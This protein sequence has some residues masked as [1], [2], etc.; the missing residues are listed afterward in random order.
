MSHC[1]LKFAVFRGSE[2]IADQNVSHEVVKLGSDP[3]SHIRLDDAR[4][5]RMHAVIESRGTEITLID[6]GN[7]GGT[8]VNG[9]R[10]DK[11]R[12]AVGDR[13]RMGD[14]EIVLE[15]TSLV[16]A[17]AKPSF[18][19]SDN[20]FTASAFAVDADALNPFR[21]A[22]R[23]A[24]ERSKLEVPA[25]AAPGTYTY[26]IVKSGPDVPSEEV[27]IAGSSAIEVTVMWG[28]SVLHVGHLPRERGFS[29]GE[30]ENKAKK[31]DFFLPEEKLGTSEL[32][33]V[34]AGGLLVIPPAATGFVELPGRARMTLDEAR[35]MGQATAEVA[36]G[37]SLALPQG[38]RARIELG[39]FA[40]LVAAVTA[41]KPARRGLFS[42]FDAAMGGFFGTTLFSAAAVVAAMAYFVPPLGLT[43]DESADRENAMLIQQ[44]L[45]TAAEREMLQREEPSAEEAQAA[46]ESGTGERHAGEEGEAGKPTSTATN[47]RYGVKNN[48]A[49]PQLAKEMTRTEVE[50]FGMIGLLNTGINADPNAPTSPFGGNLSSGLDDVS[51]QGNMWGDEIGESR[52]LGGLGLSGVGEGGGCE[53]GCTGIGLGYIGTFGHGSGMGPGQ[54]FGNSH[55]RLA[56]G[57]KPKGAPKVREAP[58]QVSGRLPPE[59]IQRIVRQNHGRFRMCY[60]GGLARNP[61]LEGR[62]AVRF[63][64]GRDGAVSNVGN[65]GSDLPDSAAVG[66]VISA[67]YGLS[68]PQPDN[69][70]VTVVYPIAF[71]PG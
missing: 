35:A 45:A 29:V 33:I 39:G 61:N 3:K 6:L 38:A 9:V 2:K 48:G 47:K 8:L 56:N 51:A 4:V 16:G 69:G 20:P 25:D 13:I 54:G 12:L 50:N 59:V 53:N 49:E 26:S 60:E 70:I 11:C 23:I 19:N 44:Y 42:S 27:E 57:Y 15:A 24:T 52:G 32:S 58:A 37:K 18:L 31:A 71:S 65:G 66:C 34:L 10:V 46:A 63:V 67:F 14:T 21:S 62:V 30:T 68:F 28:D 22:A 43:D 64:I 36:G 1:A 7:E 40:F 17:P 41:G 5:G 55:G